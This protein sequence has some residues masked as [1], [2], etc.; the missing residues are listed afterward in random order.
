MVITRGDEFG[1]AQSH[2]STLVASLQAD[3]YRV[4]VIAGS[5][6]IWTDALAAEGVTVHVLERMTR[7]INPLRDL[8][9]IRELRVL[10]EAIG[11]D[12]VHAHSSKAGLVARLAAI[13][14]GIPCVFTAHGWAFTEGVSLPKRMVFRTIEQVMA[15]LAAR[16]VC[17]SAFDR[18]LALRAWMSGNR[19]MTVYNGV[20]DIDASLLAT[21]ESGTPVRAI[22]VARFASQKA[23][24]QLVEAA[25]GIP[26]LH[27]D[28]VGTGPTQA[29]IRDLVETVGMANRVRFLGERSDVPALLAASQIFVLTSN[30]EGFPMSTLEAMRASL[31]VV[32]S[33]VGGAAE[34]VE[35]AVSG[36]VI[37]RGNVAQLRERLA[38]LV[39]KPER[40]ALMGANARRRYLE[41][42][43]DTV[44]VRQVETVYVQALNTG[45]RATVP[46][47]LHPHPERVS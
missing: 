43:S 12:L 14:A 15:P 41:R 33:D 28:F 21:P 6:G 36:Y 25:A 13:Q 40:R 11:P 19:V 17:V 46:P 9:T 35:D 10:L 29:A 42:F 4:D 7:S 8:R 30:F 16:I 3:G 38:L 44:M 32:V 37:E 1:G 47:A 24:R 22:M 39:S 31:P 45:R 27:I 5:A 26:D 20:A 2:V 34:A 23:Q 18:A